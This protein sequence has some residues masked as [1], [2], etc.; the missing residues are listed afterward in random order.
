MMI[1]ILEVQQDQQIFLFRIPRYLINLFTVPL[2]SYGFFTKYF[3]CKTVRLQFDIRA[4]VVD[5]QWMV[6]S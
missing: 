1:S 6:Y 3:V 2:L 4:L 5:S